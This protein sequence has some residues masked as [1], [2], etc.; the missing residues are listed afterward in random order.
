MGL[1]GGRAVCGWSAGDL[2]ALHGHPVGVS[3]ACACGAC[4]S[5]TRQHWVPA[6]LPAQP[7]EQRREQLGHGAPD[8][9][10]P[11]TPCRDCQARATAWQSP[12]TVL[13]AAHPHPKPGPPA[14][15]PAQAAPALVGWCG[16]QHPRCPAAGQ[17]L[18]ATMLHE[19]QPGCHQIAHDAIPPN[20]RQR[21]RALNPTK[22][23]PAALGLPQTSSI[24]ARCEHVE[25]W[26]EVG[27]RESAQA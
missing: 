9:A 19:H 18:V 16:S 7:A 24:V 13:G 27:K 10:C 21:G 17:P 5:P 11:K 4:E 22:L 1:R 6:E 3:A 14:A 20:S 23:P 25:P 2:S 15:Q 8:A 26:L 12:R